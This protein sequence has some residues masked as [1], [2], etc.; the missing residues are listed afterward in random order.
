LV[1]PNV[2]IILVILLEPVML[3]IVVI[4]ASYVITTGRDSFNYLQD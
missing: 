1:I 3:K 4:T 2:F